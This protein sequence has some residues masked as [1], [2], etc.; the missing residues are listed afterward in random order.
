MP[1]IAVLLKL[2]P[3]MILVR[4]ITQPLLAAHDYRVYRFIQTSQRTRCYEPTQLRD[5]PAYVAVD[6][7]SAGSSIGTGL[8][9]A[10]I[11]NNIAHLACESLAT[12]TAEAVDAIHTGPVVHA[13]A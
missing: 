13:G 10:F 6:D 4:N 7:V 8:R 1:V 3:Q 2:F 12:L 5:S 11:D 9:G